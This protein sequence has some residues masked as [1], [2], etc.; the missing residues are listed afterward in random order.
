ML[1]IVGPAHGLC[2][3]MV[4]TED[5]GRV[6]WCQNLFVAQ[7]F[8]V[9]TFSNTTFFSHTFRSVLIRFPD[10]GLVLQGRPNLKLFNQLFWLILI[11]YCCIGLVMAPLSSIMNGS[12]AQLFVAKICILPPGLKLDSYESFKQI[13][14]QQVDSSL[15]E[16]RLL[17][18]LD[19]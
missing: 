10:R 5:I 18:I 11:P 16:L 3:L 14:S 4:S 7:N 12:F 19:L 17:S 8:L 15:A 6:F 1:G 13:M 9:V 2:L